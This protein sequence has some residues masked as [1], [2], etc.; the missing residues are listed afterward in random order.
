[1]AFVLTYDSLTS[2][3][4]TYLE[5]NDSSLI[6]NIPI[7][8]MLGERRASRDLK[9]L[10]L[11]VAITDNLIVN[12]TTFQKPTRWLNDS[13]F[14]IGTNVELAEGYN[15]RVFLLQRSYEWC[16]TY[17]PDPTQLGTPKYY[18]SDYNYNFWFL[19]PTPDQT[20]PYEILYYE[21]PQL[22]DDTISSNYLS[23]SVPEV[24][25][26]ATLLETA[27]YLKD[28]ERIGVWTDYY[29]KAR[30]NVGDEDIRRIYDAYSK[31]GG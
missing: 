29:E 21:T 13:S 5:R 22:L 2:A 25:L 28:D 3:V 17:W 8:I 26:Y 6:S 23:G 14:N 1:M 9:I 4:Q 7:F 16:R 18:S 15:T 19:V 10:G 30:K 11:K 27:S 12:Q 24:L 31:R 20:Y